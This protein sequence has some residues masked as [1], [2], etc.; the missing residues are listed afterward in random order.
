MRANE[1]EQMFWPPISTT[2]RWPVGLMLTAIEDAEDSVEGIQ[3]AAGRLLHAGVAITRRSH[4]HV[5]AEYRTGYAEGLTTSTL[6]CCKRAGKTTLES[7]KWHYHYARQPHQPPPRLLPGERGDE[8]RDAAIEALSAIARDPRWGRSGLNA[9]SLTTRVGLCRQLSALHAETRNWLLPGRDG[10]KYLKDDDRQALK[11]RQL[12]GTSSTANA[13][14][15]AT[16]DEAAPYQV[17][18]LEMSVESPLQWRPQLRMDGDVHSTHQGAIAAVEWRRHGA[19]DG[20]GPK[21]W[22]SD[23]GRTATGYIEADNCGEPVDWEMLLQRVAS[24][25]C[26]RTICVN[27]RNADA[28][29]A[30][31]AEAG[32]VHEAWCEWTPGDPAGR[33]TDR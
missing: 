20:A 18:A 5:E 21:I 28:V 10:P 25:E 22:L 8:G 26:W 33:G 19:E 15:R 1:G 30:R 32:T 16:L 13:T 23:A 4:E 31:L 14:I 17:T 12:C 11:L 3:A 27:G 9:Y 24:H 7:Q 6:R 2:S 29:R